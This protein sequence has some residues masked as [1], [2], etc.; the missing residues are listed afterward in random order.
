MSMRGRKR[1]MGNDAEMS[2]HES[3][4]ESLEGGCGKEQP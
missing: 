1:T 3:G 2:V 4:D